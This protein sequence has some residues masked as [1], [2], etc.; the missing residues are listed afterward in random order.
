MK[1]LSGKP[2]AA[3]ADPT[4]I[5]TS[6]EAVA[7]LE[8]LVCDAL[9]RNS[10]NEDASGSVTGTSHY[11]FNA[12]GRQVAE[13]SVETVTESLATASGMALAGSRVA[14]FFTGDRILEGYQQ[15]QFIADHHIPMVLHPLLREGY[16]PGSNHSGYHGIADIGLF[17]V[18]PHTVQQAA[19]YTVLA[20]WLAERSLVPGVVGID[21]N[22]IEPASLLPAAKLRSFLGSAGSPLN[23][24]TPSQLLLFGGER[25]QVPS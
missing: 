20:H 22:R 12:F 24:P 7:V 25:R 15:I 1:V 18:M 9:V 19:D 4:E 17:Q 5:L 3:Q 6:V 2:E 16:G 14:S 11:G 23:S 8:N 10:L 13:I 21:R